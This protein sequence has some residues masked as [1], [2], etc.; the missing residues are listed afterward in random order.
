MYIA[1]GSCRVLVTMSHSKYKC[2]N[3]WSEVDKRNI[4]PNKIASNLSIVPVLKKFE[5]K[6]LLKNS[7]LTHPFFNN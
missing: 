7:K 6:L 2:L 5:S 3:T 4:K 1:L